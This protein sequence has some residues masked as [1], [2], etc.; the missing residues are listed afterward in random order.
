M[1]SYHTT[2][3]GLKVIQF[4]ASKRKRMSIRL[5]RVSDRD[6]GRI[7]EKVEGL[8]TARRHN[9]TPPAALVE[10]LAGID[11]VLHDRIAKV[12]LCEPRKGRVAVTIGELVKRFTATRKGVKASTRANWKQGHDSIIAYFG[13]DRDI[14]SITASD[15]IGWR[16]SQIGQVKEATIR[17]RTR[18][19]KLLF[20]WAI[21]HELIRRN[22]FKHKRIPSSSIA[23]QQKP[24]V[25]CEVADKVIDALPDW[26]WRLF[27]ALGRYAGLRL[28]SEALALRWSHID[29]E[30][31]RMRVPVPKLEHHEGKG[32]RVVPIF[33]ELRPYLLDAHEAV[34]D[35]ETRVVP[36]PDM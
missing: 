34:E 16:E 30:H 11:D 1:A 18:M 21:D 22:P 3:D 2:G 15:A 32:E 7:L 35:G 28:P 24:Y 8:I 33:A 17:K 36:I 26:R 12:G 31:N 6:A 25:T 19:V 9:D 23:G 5:G 14:T 4:R 20:N 10:W 27:F 13:A 29:F